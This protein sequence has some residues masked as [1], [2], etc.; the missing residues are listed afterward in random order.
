MGHDPPVQFDECGAGLAE[1][2]IVF[3]QLAEVREFVGRQ[4]AQAGFTV[5]G[6]GNQGGSVERPLVR[7]A[8]T[9]GLAAASEE[10][11]D[12]TFDELTEGEQGIELTLVIIEQR[13]EGLTQTA[14]AF[15]RGGQ[16]RFSSLCY[17]T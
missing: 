8:V 7:G 15:R 3:S 13:L 6:P 9:G 16:R 10:V 11:V 4:G 5:L 14:R 2:S 12:R 17:T 1:A